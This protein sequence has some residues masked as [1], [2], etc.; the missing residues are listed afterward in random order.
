MADCLLVDRDYGAATPAHKAKSVNPIHFADV[1]LDYRSLHLDPV[2]FHI[3]SFALRWYSIA[4]IAGILVA[5]WYILRLLKKPGA[6][7]S[8][9][10]VDSFVTYLTIGM[11]GGGRLGY[12]LFYNFAEYLAHP[13][14]ALKL[15]EGGMSFHGALIGILL[16]IW[17]F[18]RVHKLQFLRF[19]DY[20][21]CTIPFGLCFGRIANFINGELWGAPTTL[22]W[23]VIFP[24]GGPSPRHP[25]QLYEAFLEG[26]V[27]FGILWWLFNR[28]DAR[29]KPGYLA[30]AFALFYGLFRF[31]VEFI[32]ESDAQLAG[33]AARTGLHMGQWLS[34]PLILVGIYFMATA[35]GRRVRVEPIAGT[36]SQ[37]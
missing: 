3:G 36:A 6:P 28:T 34:L 8:A 15:W 20:V 24:D 17:L 29:Y 22:P 2:I 32:R 25:S 11:I 12:I 4:Y 10:H 16:A 21:A 1:A 9:A 14:D 18:V 19:C 13:L 31:L 5:W 33:F 35:K 27:L 30:G 37:A 23:G 26:P 7:M